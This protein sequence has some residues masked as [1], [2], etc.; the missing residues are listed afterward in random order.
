MAHCPLETSQEWKD[1]LALNEGNEDLTWNQ[2]YMYG[3]GDIEKFPDINKKVDNKDA[4]EA[5]KVAKKVD[6]KQEDKDPMEKLM[7]KTK[8][9]L[10]T[11]IAALRRVKKP[12]ERT[13][14]RLTQLVE[15]MED[16]DAVQSII[17]FVDEGM[18]VEQ[19]QEE[20][21]RSKR[22]A[23]DLTEESYM[24]TKWNNCQF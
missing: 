11:R 10:R 19:L 23:K 4:E 6:K 9:H 1:L 18:T 7:D 16:V 22:Y 13:I 17:M 5:E 20:Y 14:D 12:K 15:N 24:D 2:W 3:Y 21:N 8:L